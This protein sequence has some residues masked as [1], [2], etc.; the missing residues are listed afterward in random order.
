MQLLLSLVI[1]ALAVFATAKI[2][3]NVFVADLYSALITAF[4]LGLVNT[5]IKPILVL[6]TLPITVLTLGLFSLVINAFMI[7]LVDKFVAGFSVDG[8][9]TAI[10]FS[11][12]LSIV[13]SILNNLFN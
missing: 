8:F 6:F 5:F 12:V 9:L 3:P 13:S 4:A 11:L 1:N 10:L 2:I 7:L